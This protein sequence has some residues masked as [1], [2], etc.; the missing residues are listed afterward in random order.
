MKTERFELRLT[1]QEKEV[2]QLEAGRLGITP[3]DYIRIKACGTAVVRAP[4]ESVEKPGY[5]KFVEEDKKKKTKFT[6]TA[7]WPTNDFS[8]KRACKRCRWANG[9]DP[10]CPIINA[11]TY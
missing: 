3:S 10:L 8:R 4:I 1:K 2:I 7:N 11:E 6:P 9:H 5:D